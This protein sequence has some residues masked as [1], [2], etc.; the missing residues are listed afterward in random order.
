MHI[1]LAH[2]ILNESNA[3]FFIIDHFYIFNTILSTGIQTYIH[4]VVM[5]AR[6]VHSTS[7]FDVVKVMTF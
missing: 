2:G 3:S 5:L 7:F 1:Y 6:Y 4:K